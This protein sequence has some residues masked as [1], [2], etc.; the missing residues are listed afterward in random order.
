MQF[1]I[2]IPEKGTN[3][4]LVN[5]LDCTTLA[6]ESLE[7]PYTSKRPTIILAEELYNEERFK[8]RKIS[9]ALVEKYNKLEEEGNWDEIEK[10]SEGLTLADTTPVIIP[11]GTILKITHKSSLIFSIPSMGMKLV[12]SNKDAKGILFEEVTAQ[13]AKKKAPKSNI[14]I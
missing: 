6:E 7:V 8:G 9:D 4:R 10:L 12:L 13:E 3:L 5:D 14:K 2:V 11:A 1:T